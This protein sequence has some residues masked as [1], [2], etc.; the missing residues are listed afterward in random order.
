MNVTI[1]YFVTIS[2][3]YTFHLQVKTRR[4]SNKLHILIFVFFCFRKDNSLYYICLLS[5]VS[6][7]QFC[8]PFWGAGFVH[9]RDLV[10]VPPPQL[11][12][13]VVHIVHG[14]KPPSTGDNRCNRV[15]CVLMYTNR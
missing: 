12:G 14:V 9:V 1:K 6:P 11:T 10:L 13:H 8:P 2:E 5:V 3:Q 15:V 7:T 4:V